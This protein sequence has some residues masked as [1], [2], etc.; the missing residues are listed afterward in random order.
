MV[1]GEAVSA[2]FPAPDGLVGVLGGRGPL[3]VLLG[4]GPLTL[5]ELGGGESVYFVSGGFARFN[6]N[7]LTLLTEECVPVHEIDPEATWQEIER[8]QQ[9]P[10][11]TPEQAEMREEAL[12]AAREKFRLAQKHRKQAGE[13]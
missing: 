3:V 4:S 7:V 12:Q 6:D 1:A 8:A 10:R 11:E 5:R 9:L 13:L 2:V